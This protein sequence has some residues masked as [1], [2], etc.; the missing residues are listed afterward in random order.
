M[1]SVDIQC[2][3]GN[4]NCHNWILI[5]KGSVWIN[6]KEVEGWLHFDA[7]NMAGASVEIM[8]P[9]AEAESIAAFLREE[10]DRPSLLIQYACTAL[11]LIC[12]A[13]LVLIFIRT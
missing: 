13:L 1:A 7:T 11:S 3:C 5:R 4:P 8:L 2:E 6:N 10:F 9:P 12:L